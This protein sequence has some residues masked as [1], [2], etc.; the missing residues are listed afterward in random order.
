MDPR[1]T[2]IM[3]MYADLARRRREEQEAYE[4]RNPTPKP[5]LPNPFPDYGHIGQRALLYPPRKRK[6]K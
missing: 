4:K 1:G 6:R 3:T 2:N 5:K